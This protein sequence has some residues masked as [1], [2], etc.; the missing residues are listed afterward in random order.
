MRIANNGTTRLINELTA[1]S[2]AATWKQKEEYKQEY[3]QEYT[4]EHK[5]TNRSTDKNTHEYTTYTKRRC[6]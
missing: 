5:S 1:D 4:Q 6:R 2:H 3:K